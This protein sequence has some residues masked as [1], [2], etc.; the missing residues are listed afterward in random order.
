[1]ADSNHT[2]KASSSL[3]PTLT[4]KNGLV[5]LE[6]PGWHPLHTYES[7]PPCVLTRHK[8]GQQKSGAGEQ[9]LCVH[10][11]TVSEPCLPNGCGSVLVALATRVIPGFQ[12]LLFAKQGKGEMGSQATESY[13]GQMG[14]QTGHPD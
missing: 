5:G 12:E 4:L 1:M 13:S 2:F 8:L 10:T 14:R 7:I 9:L 3:A 11:W 6:R